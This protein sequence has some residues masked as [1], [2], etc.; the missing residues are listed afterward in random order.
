MSRLTGPLKIE[1]LAYGGK[2]IARSDGKVLFVAGAAPGDLAICRLTREKKRHA[3]AELVE[4]LEPSPQRR[5]PP[6]PVADR[7]G[8][9][10]W[11]YLPYADQCRW[12]DEIFR[13]LLQRQAGADP[14]RILPIVPAPREWQ[15]RSRVQF[16][17]ARRQGRFLSGFYRTGS[18]D[19]VDVDRCPVLAQE[20]NAV[21]AQIKPLLA[22]SPFAGSIPQIDMGVGDDGQVRVVLHTRGDGR[23]LA[24]YCRPLAERAGF[25]LFL[26]SERRSA[27]QHVCGPI[28]LQISV[29][30]PPL[31]LGYGP[32]GF[33]QIN[34]QQNRA[35]VA[36]VVRAAQLTGSE[37]VLDL[38]CGMGN[39]SLPLA[40]RAG[41]VVAVEENAPSID[42]GRENAAANGIANLSFVCRPADGF[43]S[44]AAV[45]A[46]F[47]LVLLDPPRSGA[48]SVAIELLQH[49]PRKIAYVSCDPATLARDL[50][51][52]LAGG[53]RLVSSRPFD[54]FPQTYHVESLTVLERDR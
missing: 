27:P 3:E 30:Q 7:C 46:Y 17:C 29:D 13:D 52:L 42:K 20:L 1:S 11:Q 28:D 48:G 31:R 41:Q 24:A 18:H 19:V 47:D 5:T 36:A 44:E 2:A 49:R 53:Y 51:L 32:R 22:A 16:K 33:A 40:R 9:C 21:L 26:Q 39:F 12:K 10:Q 38:Y 45:Q 4:L 15:Y 6:C 43:L 8:G 14:Q 50:K 23:A 34:A 25:S 54:M 35:L 37:A